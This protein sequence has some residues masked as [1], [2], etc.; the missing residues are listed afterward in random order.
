MTVPGDSRKCSTH[1]ARYPTKAN[2]VRNFFRTRLHADHS[3][4]NGKGKS[5]AKTALIPPRGASQPLHPDSD[6]AQP[7]K[8][9]RSRRTRG[10]R[11]TPAPLP[12]DN[13][14]HAAHFTP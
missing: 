11:A 10:S 2:A 12:T 7:E 1:L 9:L 13:P 3:R 5:S 4:W 6:P 8:R 14:A